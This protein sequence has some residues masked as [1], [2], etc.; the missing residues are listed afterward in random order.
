LD[1][2]IPFYI[3]LKRYLFVNFFRNI[4][5]ID[6]ILDGSIERKSVNIVIYFFFINIY[7]LIY[8][9]IIIMIYIA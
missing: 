6:K 9:L 2:V 3:F 1:R 8:V 4:Q 7:L 5:T